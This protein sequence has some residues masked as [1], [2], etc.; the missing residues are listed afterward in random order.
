MDLASLTIVPLF[1]AVPRGFQGPV[2]SLLFRTESDT[3]FQKHARH[4][5]SV[6]RIAAA[7]LP[8]AAISEGRCRKL[9]SIAA[10]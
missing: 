6:T 7:T 2:E 5:D 8:P 9:F 10:N 3:F 4:D 1:C